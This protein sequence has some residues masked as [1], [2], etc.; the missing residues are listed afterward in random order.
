MSPCTT[1]ADHTALMHFT[2]PL[3]LPGTSGRFRIIDVDGEQPLTL[4]ARREALEILPGQPIEQLVYHT[5]QGGQTT[6]H[7][8]L[9][10]RAGAT[11]TAELVNQLAEDTTL[12]WH[13][14][15][16]AEAVDGSHLY[17]VA[18]GERRIYQFPV[19]NRSGLYWYHPHA[20]GST[21]RQVYEGLAGLLV[22]EDDEELALRAA[23]DLELGVTD[24]PLVLQDRRLAHDGRVVY[25]PDPISAVMGYEGETIL[26]NQ[27]PKPTLSVATRLYRFRVLNGAN[28]R[29]FRLA[30]VAAEDGQVVPVTLIGTDGGLLTHPVSVHELFLAPGERADLLLDLRDATVGATLALVSLAFD[31]MHHG[32]GSGGPPAHGSQGAGRPAGAMGG[33]YQ[34]PTLASGAAFPILRL[35]VTRA[36]PYYR[37]IPS[38]LSR[39]A[40]METSAALERK[41]ALSLEVGMCE[42]RMAMQWLIAGQR[43][44]LDRDAIVVQRNSTEIWAFAN[45]A[46]SMPHPMHLHGFSF[47]VLSREGSPPQVAALALDDEGRTATDLGWKDT[48][49]VWPGETVRVII[50]FAHPFPGAQRY[51]VHCHMLEHEENGMMLHV[52]VA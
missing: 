38:P 43:L 23:L 18:P 31:P 15:H 37:A 9:R 12:H 39:L 4:T 3:R 29:T 36:E 19:L 45:V 33:M 34:P 46:R 13:G 8:V 1:I 50:R 47:Q 25:A 17:P 40:P 10:V 22:V 44:E 14:L 41:L 5:A 52:R 11:F 51:M 7:P 20:H 30:V 16:V 48:V 49:L 28:T 2:T 6:L 27:T 32:M 42:G 26:V 21:A 24:I 35:D